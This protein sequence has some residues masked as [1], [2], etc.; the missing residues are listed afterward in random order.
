MTPVQRSRA[1]RKAMQ[2]IYQW[3]L[4]ALD[5]VE[6]QKQFEIFEDMSRID[7][8]YFEELI[9]NIP[10]H[11]QEIDLQLTPF[12]KDDIKQINLVERAILRISTY[13][14]LFRV[15]IPFQVVINEAIELAKSFSGGETGYKLVNSILDKLSLQ[16]REEKNEAKQTS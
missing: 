8:E 9:Q 1:R 7:K 15:E 13:E 5:P 6:I 10:E 14:L 2:A 12:F 3:Q 16:L 4:T 11:I